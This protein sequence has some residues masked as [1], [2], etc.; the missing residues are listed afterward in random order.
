MKTLIFI[1]I[2]S[3]SV[4]MLTEGCKGKINEPEGTVIQTEETINEADEIIP[5]TKMIKKP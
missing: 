1:I 4:L 5:E 2:M 3:V